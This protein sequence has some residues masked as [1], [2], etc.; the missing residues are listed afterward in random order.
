M[1]EDYAK[2]AGKLG[3]RHRVGKWGIQWFPRDPEGHIYK[4]VGITPLDN[5]V[6]DPEETQRIMAERGYEL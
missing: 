2:V 1:K 5:W 4:L 6:L 3:I